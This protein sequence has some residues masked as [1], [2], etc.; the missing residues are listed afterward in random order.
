M[1]KK[2]KLKECFGHYV[3]GNDECEKCPQGNACF[4]NGVV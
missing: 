1:S 2:I 4:E 3:S